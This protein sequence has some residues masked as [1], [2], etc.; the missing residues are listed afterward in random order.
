MNINQYH[1]AE[2]EDKT[3]K[4]IQ[5]AEQKL[6]LVL[7]ALEP[8]PAPAKLTQEQLIQLKKLEEETGK[9]LVAYHQ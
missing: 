8:D 7:L 3:L 2:L 5:Q 9:V 4:K 6:G 1:T